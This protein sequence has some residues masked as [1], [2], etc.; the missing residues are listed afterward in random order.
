M[1]GTTYDNPNV[2]QYLGGYQD[3]SIQD[4][5]GLPN[6]GG[7]LQFPLGL[8][9]GLSTATI[10]FTL[11]M[12]YKRATKTGGFYSTKQNEDLY[13]TLP[14]P[15]FAIALPTPSSALKTN[16]AAIYSPFDVGQAIGSIGGALGS[17]VDSVFSKDGTATDALKKLGQG[18][19]SAT[20]QAGVAVIQAA[21]EAAG[22]GAGIMNVAIGQ[23][24]NPYAENVFKNVEFRSHDFAYT[25]MPRNKAES[26]QIDRIIQV[27]KFAMLPRPG[28]GS[29]AG[30]FGYFDFPYEFQITHSIQSTTFTLLPSVL[31]SFDVDYS[32]GADTPKL[33][34][35][36][37]R[38]QYPAKISI[39]MRFK[40]MVLLTR[41]RILQ[42]V[43]STNETSLGD[44]DTGDKLR[45]RF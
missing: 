38:G 1:A 5:S 4:L 41:N 12:P 32:G 37:G 42:D 19:A 3:K 10:P 14:Q 26:E 11:F 44:P 13:T 39:S 7:V 43:N 40:E 8:G 16:Y 22:G 23:A 17:A 20:K 35:L 21:L 30:Q 18:A 24:D 28:S 6:R 34:N 2:F 15:D 25:F 29:I 27:F 33:F 36:T 31:E 9:A 45:F